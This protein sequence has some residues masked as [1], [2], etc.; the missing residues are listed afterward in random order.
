MFL[1]IAIGICLL[2]LMMGIPAA[3]WGRK[4]KGRKQALI[5]GVVFSICAM[6]WTSV[7]FVVIPPQV[8]AVA[9]MAIAFYL[10]GRWQKYVRVFCGGLLGMVVAA[11]L[12]KLGLIDLIGL[13]WV[14]KLLFYVLCFG[15]GVALTLKF[16]AEIIIAM[17]AFAGANVASTAALGGMMI[18]N[19][20]AQYFVQDVV[21]ET[22]FPILSFFLD[23][24]TLAES[25]VGYL[26]FWFIFLSGIAFQYYCKRL[27]ER[28]QAAS[29]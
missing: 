13:S 20:R 7:E 21:L 19:E 8:V 27:D 25:S 16:Y 26:G 29:S 15:V 5:E 12:N 3:Y 10:S 28:T 22:L 6:I 4:L 24:A 14:G 2:T 11:V 23:N 1:Y 9:A 18:A 17:T